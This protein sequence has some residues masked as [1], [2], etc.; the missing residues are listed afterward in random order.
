MPS[1]DLGHAEPDL[2]DLD[3]DQDEHE[4]VSPLT[5]QAQRSRWEVDALLARIESLLSTPIGREMLARADRRSLAAST[6]RAKAVA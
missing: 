5:R 6:S 1:I 3:D 2:D 4:N